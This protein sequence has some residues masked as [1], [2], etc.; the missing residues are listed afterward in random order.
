MKTILIVVLLV[1]GGILLFWLMPSY[2][3]IDSK[4]CLRGKPALAWQ[5]KEVCQK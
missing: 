1:I 3:F 5:Y 4:G 2:T